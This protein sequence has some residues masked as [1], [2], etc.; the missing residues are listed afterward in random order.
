MMAWAR[1]F[2]LAL[3]PTVLWDAIAGFLL[4][5]VLIQRSLAV[6][7]QAFETGPP[8]SSFQW[9]GS[10][11]AI[12]CGI[13]LCIFHAGMGLNDWADRKID[14]AANRKRP[15]SLGQIKP[16]AVIPAV[17]M[18]LVGAAV[19]AF[20]YF[21]EPNWIYSLIALVLV[22]DLCGSTLRT[23]IG[24]LLLALCRSLSFSCGMLVLLS[25]TALAS[26]PAPWAIAAYALYVLFLARLAA[27]EEEGGQ[28]LNLLPFIALMCLSP[29]SL[30][31]IP[32]ANSLWLHL[33]WLGLA[34]WHL[35]PAVADR[36]QYWDPQRVQAAVRR[37][38]VA[39]PVLP[40]MA[41]LAVGAPPWW[42]LFGL[43]V[44]AVTVTLA[45]SMAPE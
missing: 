14:L 34:A 24:P 9:A 28:G 20:L 43:A 39:M 12:T 16:Q 35:W 29:F 8:M 37:S 26:S 38:L 2:R 19:S 6:S 13:L 17:F 10:T 3:A 42:S 15:I 22:Y 21:P 32:N 30:T 41:L 40:A 7:N 27:K 4:A 25:P 18:L 5:D 44:A 1:L 36:H 23:G 33:T 11:L 31:Q 45:R